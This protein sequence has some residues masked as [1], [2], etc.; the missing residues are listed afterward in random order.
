MRERVRV[1]VESYYHRYITVCFVKFSTKNS[2]RQTWGKTRF[3][4]TES[5]IHTGATK[6]SSCQ[7]VGFRV[8]YNRRSTMAGVDDAG[9]DWAAVVVVVVRGENATQKRGFVGVELK[10]TATFMFRCFDTT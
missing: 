3:S 4:C 10:M 8:L 1:S 2:C 6:Y 7:L 9:K 5:S